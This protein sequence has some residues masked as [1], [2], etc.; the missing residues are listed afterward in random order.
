L[1]FF[2]T[3]L[4]SALAARLFIELK[5]GNSI[6]E[7]LQDQAQWWATTYHTGGD[8]ATFETTVTDFESGKFGKEL[9]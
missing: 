5:L 2:S 9:L 4:Q 1:R 3:P 8:P 7:M 6:P